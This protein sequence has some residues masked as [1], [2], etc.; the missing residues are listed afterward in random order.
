VL[1][2]TLHQLGEVAEA[3]VPGE[4]LAFSHE[5]TFSCRVR[6]LPEASQ[7][8]S[9]AWHSPTKDLVLFILPPV[10]SARSQLRSWYQYRRASQVD[11]GLGEGSINQDRMWATCFSRAIRS[12]S[13]S[14]VRNRI[15]KAASVVFLPG[16]PTSEP[17]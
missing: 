16:E 9:S 2:Q 6:A 14:H 12:L 8:S 10:A 13:S 1:E 15:A 7:P 4:S 11:A 3:G 17:I 5:S